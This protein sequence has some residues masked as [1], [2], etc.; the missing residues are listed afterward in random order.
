[1]IE[2]IRHV[3][4]NETGVEAD[5]ILVAIEN[6]TVGSAETPPLKPGTNALT[7]LLTKKGAQCAKRTFFLP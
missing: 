6:P 4:A 1:M 2:Q 3:E 7:I 5:G